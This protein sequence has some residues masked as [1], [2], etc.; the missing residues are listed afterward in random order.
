MMIIENIYKLNLDLLVVLDVLIEERCNYTSFDDGNNGID[1]AAHNGDDNQDGSDYGYE[2]EKCGYEDDDQLVTAIA[3]FSI[4]ATVIITALAAGE[5]Y[6]ED[7]VFTN[8]DIEDNNDDS[9][10]LILILILN[11]ILIFFFILILIPILIL[12]FILMLVRTPIVP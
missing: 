8:D 3:C 5:N 7:G 9:Y 1:S 6:F 10:L 11:P 4:D 2:D 12:I